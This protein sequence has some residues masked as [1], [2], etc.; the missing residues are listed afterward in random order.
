ME[1]FYERLGISRNASAEQI[2]KAYRQKSL[3]FHPDRNLDKVKWAEEK[4]KEISE[5]YET[6]YDAARRKEYDRR[7]PQKFNRQKAQQQPQKKNKPPTDPEERSVW[8]AQHDP[9]MGHIIDAPPPRFDIWGQPIEQE[10]NWDSQQYYE[11]PL[12]PS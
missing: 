10:K 11:P 12:S 8:I 6:L 3:L 5:A 7:N 9:N 1:D 2:R 4:F